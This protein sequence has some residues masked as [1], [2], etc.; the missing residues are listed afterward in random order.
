MKRLLKFVVALLVVTACLL[1]VVA[2]F[3]QP[4]RCVTSAGLLFDIAGILQLEVAGVFQ[5]V[6]QFLEGSEAADGTMPSRYV[7]E[8]IDSPDR[9]IRTWLRNT[10][11]F[12]PRTGLGLIILGC[13]GQ[14]VGTWL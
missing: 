12:E 9:P 2:P 4:Q 1:L 8:V 11:Y 13:L 7:R 10:L 6:L 5:A 14:L 3:S